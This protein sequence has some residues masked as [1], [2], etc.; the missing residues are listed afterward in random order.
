MSL[1]F[2]CEFHDDFFDLIFKTDTYC[3]VQVSSKRK[4]IDPD[5]PIPLEPAYIYSGGSFDG[6]KI[7]IFT[8]PSEKFPFFCRSWLETYLSRK[9]KKCRF[10]TPFLPF[11]DLSNI[12]STNQKNII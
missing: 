4:I 8:G 10:S 3:F 2:F 1:T 7:C 11:F 5:F 12:H 9:K 6:Q